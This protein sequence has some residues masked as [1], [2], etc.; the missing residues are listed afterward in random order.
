MNEIAALDS[1]SASGYP[2]DI[3]KERGFKKMTQ[4]IGQWGSSL[5]IRLPKSASFLKKGQS[6]DIVVEDNT[7]KIIPIKKM[8]SIDE[9]LINDDISTSPDLFIDFGNVGREVDL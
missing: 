7:I 2:N 9:I 5:A 1:N 4:K 6:V 8:R 3:L